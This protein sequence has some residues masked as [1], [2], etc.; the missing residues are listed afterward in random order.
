M[1]L[2][3][4][5]KEESIAFLNLVQQFA[6]I[7]NVFAKEEK[8]LIQEYLEELELKKEDVKSLTYDEVMDILKRTITRNKSIIYF[9]LV[10]LA[11]VDG[12]YEDTE[13]DFLDKI[14]NDLD[15]RR[16]RKIA[17]ANYFF[18]F[19]EVY[20]FSVVEADSKIQLLKEQAD[21]LL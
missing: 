5:N 21:E 19:K 14:A 17:F 2:N 10:G 6:N 11:L 3:E 20:D 4:L 18:N 9:E 1:F 16:D 7:D 15:I 8:R 12:A 13:I